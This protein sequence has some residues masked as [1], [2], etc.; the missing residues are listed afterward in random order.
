MLPS[1]SQGHPPLLIA[2]PVEIE[3]K[4]KN[5]AAPNKLFPPQRITHSQIDISMLQPLAQ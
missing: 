3:Q 1:A 2:T 5:N 4:A